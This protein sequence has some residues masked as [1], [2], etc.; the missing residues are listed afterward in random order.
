M[1]TLILNSYGSARLQFINPP[2]SEAQ[3]KW[4]AEIKILHYGPTYN[5]PEG[6]GNG[7]TTDKL[8]LNSYE[9][10]QSQFM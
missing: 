4:N 7:T 9:S 2:S 3:E 6:G 10:A 8:V 5:T 1:D